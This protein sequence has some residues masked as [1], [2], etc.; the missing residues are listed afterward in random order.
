MQ[1]QRSCGNEKH[2]KKNEHIN[3]KQVEQNKKSFQ[4][5]Q[6]ERSEINRAAVPVTIPVHFIIVHE[7]SEGVG[8]GQNVSLER[9]NSQIQVLNDD[10]ARSNSDAANTPSVF[11]AAATEISFCLATI[12]PMGNPTNGV[13]RY[14]Q[15]NANNSNFE[16]IENSIIQ[17]T[18]WPPTRY[19]NIYVAPNM[20]GV[21]GYSSVPSPGNLPGTNNDVVRVLT[22]AFGGEGF[23]TSAIYNLGRTATH[24]IGHWLGL[25]HVWGSGGC[26]SD[27]GF[28]DTPMQSDPNYG[29]LSHP[30]AS[31]SN[32]G[33]MFMNYMD[34]VDDNCMNAF[35]QEQ[36]DYMSFIVEGTRTNLLN[37]AIT[38]CAP[39]GSPN[40]SI[41]SLQNISCAGQQDGSIEINAVAGTPPYS[42]SLNSGP[43]QSSGI[44]ENLTSGNYT[45]SV[46][47]ADGIAS[48]LQFSIEMPS[49][50]SFSNSVLS[51]TCNG[52]TNGA[53]SISTNGGNSIFPNLQ[54]F[55]DDTFLFQ[56]NSFEEDFED[57][58]PNTWVVDTGWEYGDAQS[59]NSASFEF[60]DNGH[61]VGFNDD[62]LGQNH[63]GGGSVI[64]ENIN[65]GGITSFNVIFDAF[66]IDGDYEGADETAKVYLSGN[67]G[68]TWTEY[69]NIPGVENEWV[70]YV[71]EITD[72]TSV[73]LQIR[74]QYDDGGGWNFGLGI[75]QVVVQDMNYGT[76]DGLAAGDY[77]VRAIDA[78]GCEYDSAITINNEE[79]V[80]FNQIDIVDAN[81]NIPGELNASAT[82][83][84]GIS[85]YQI[86]FDVVSTDGNF[87]NLGVGNYTVIATDNAGCIATQSVVISDQGQLMVDVNAISHASCF[88]IG[89]G[90][91]G[92]NIS[93]ATGST[94]I[95]LDG[96]VVNST[97]F[98]ELQA[99]T[100]TV[101]VI[102]ENGCSSIT[103]ATIDEPEEL[104]FTGTLVHQTCSGNG[105]INQSATGGTG[106]YTYSILGAQQTSFFENLSPGTYIVTTMDAN[107][108]ERTD[109]FEVLDMSNG[110]NITESVSACNGGAELSYIVE[111]CTSDGTVASWMIF[112]NQGNSIINPGLGSCV[113]IDMSTFLIAQQD[114]FFYGVEA[115]VGAN[116]IQE[117]NAVANYP[118]SL[119][120][121]GESISICDDE[122]YS[123][124]FIDNSEIAMIEIIDGN[125][126]AVNPS[127]EGSYDLMAGNYSISYSVNAG[128][129]NEEEFEI[130][131]VESTAFELLT[132]LPITVCED[133]IYSLI[134]DNNTELSDFV[135]TD[136]NGVEYPENYFGFYEVVAG[137]Y[138]ISYV[139]MN[140]CSGVEFVDVNEVSNPI[141][142]I[143]FQTEA[144]S[145]IGGSIQF[146]NDSEMLTFFLFGQESN[147]TGLFENL[148]A[149]DY[150]VTAIN[151]NGCEAELEFTIQLQSS[152]ENFPL[153][154]EIKL[155]P[156]PVENILFIE[157]E[158]AQR[159]TR[160]SLYR[161]DGR[162]V[163]NILGLSNSLEVNV[164]GLEAGIYFVKLEA[165]E[166]IG[167][168]KIVKI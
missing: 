103:T 35:T 39:D 57:E 85:G 69:L 67:N 151:E 48:E 112:D 146:N 157:L 108:C 88:G 84:N 132:P 98:T 16:D 14:A 12:D 20:D 17:E 34:Y 19:L 97:E 116:C 147:T 90:A 53:I 120:L 167:Y 21:L 83:V 80:S 100:Y 50:L 154:R 153:S 47:S 43:A 81:C 148:P 115:S 63:V 106:P 124:N 136:Q 60:V 54:V 73:S 29:C 79:P 158:S 61:F 64:T 28:D 139:D 68:V 25:R 102:D 161:A 31:C 27:D 94:T 92:I 49:A 133:G 107:G 166:A 149:G 129:T 135:V 123:L 4:A 45:V 89:N 113:L 130:V 40:I 105:S 159:I 143:D 58:L 10:F 96:S 93:G 22:S 76:F 144:T 55:N 42:F 152:V 95:Y 3:P 11:S 125:N 114:D 26:S 119:G 140:G 23:A 110:F 9:I 74:F 87:S 165:G 8:Q 66:F 109:S 56:V 72:W 163:Q 86:A 155:Y 18:I 121:D 168:R 91:F 117:Y 128:C 36:A 15:N 134:V 33:D 164:S 150:N 62:G 156:N 141:I 52:Q 127:I 78:N 37:S 41:A 7:P 142:E 5:W 111:L 104:I 99:G 32:G 6:K 118:S 101:E 38:A 82:S 51:E 137:S 2:A 44:F 145:D 30:S 70:N 71:I 126:I 77:T 65:L 59:L 138:S 162:L 160:L 1:A 24:E 75:D 13:T 46:A 131:Q 122:I